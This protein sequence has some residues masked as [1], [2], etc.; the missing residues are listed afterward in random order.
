MAHLALRDWQ[1]SALER[2][3]V[4][5]RSSKNF[6]LEAGTGT[7]KTIAAVALLHHEIEVNGR[8]RVCIVVPTNHLKYQW[9][10]ELSALMGYRFCANYNP[11]LGWPGAG[12]N[13]IIVTYQQMANSAV[14][15]SEIMDGGVLL[16]DEIHHA[17][18]GTWGMG[19]EIIQA[20]TAVN[21]GLSATLFRT[22]NYRIPGVNYV[23]D[24]G[25]PDFRYSYKQA[26]S[27]GVVRP[28][29]FVTH[30]GEIG[31]KEG[32]GDYYSTFGDDDFPERL[33]PRRL[34]VALMPETGWITPLL[35]EAHEM[36]LSVRR[37]DPK[38]GGLIVADDQAHARKIA[39]LLAKEL[40]IKPV[41]VL[42]DEPDS[43]ANLSAF[44]NG[45]GVWCVSCN[46]I[47]EGVNTRRVR[48]AAFLK[49][50]TTRL[51]F[52]QFMG[53]LVRIGQGDEGKAPSYC[54]LP[55]DPRLVAIAQT[56][57]DD[58][59]SLVERTPTGSV[60]ATEG[61]GEG[62]VLPSLVL[63]AVNAKND[64]IDA[65][66]MSGQRLPIS[67]L[68][69]DTPNAKIHEHVPETAVT[70]GP[71]SE[72]A[73]KALAAEINR[74]ATIIYHSD[75]GNQPYKF[76]YGELN[77]MQGV[78][79]QEYCTTKQLIERC[80]YLAQKAGVPLGINPEDYL[81]KKRPLPLTSRSIGRLD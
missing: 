2:Y 11:R 57:E 63:G 66:I 16:Q 28:V 61:G 35:K 7:G 21:I 23:D 77:K 33:Y 79:G 58:I 70:D 32:G 20:R 80:R 18:I 54:Y 34:Q 44:L 49:R 39:A 68:L 56:V 75:K 59:P 46:M 60:D 6:L 40:D 71:T 8:K 36:L 27:D 29:V 12:Y 52:I 37:R 19:L 25:V 17:G 5:T 72:A 55:A 73:Y 14:K 78:K 41:L 62:D 64:G 50:V 48:V 22:D 47:S 13:G 24:V 74:L 81:P 30:E 1:K 38:A 26:I 53:R 42:S 69:V 3:K 67:T 51:Y 65:V 10:D 9:Q 43:T 4:V 31:W 76:I 15:L 45:R